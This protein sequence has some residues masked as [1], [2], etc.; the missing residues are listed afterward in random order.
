MLKKIVL[1]VGASFSALFAIYLLRRKTCSKNSKET[2]NDAKN[3]MKQNYVNNK[4]STADSVK[5]GIIQALEQDVLQGLE[6]NS[7]KEINDSGSSK[8]GANSDPSNELQSCSKNIVNEP[9]SLNGSVSAC[10]SET[11]QAKTSSLQNQLNNDH[12][13]SLT[14]TEAQDYQEDSKEKI[15]AIKEDKQ[16]AVAASSDTQKKPSEKASTPLQGDL[17]DT[18]DLP[19]ILIPETNL[20]SLEVIVSSSNSHLVMNGSDSSSSNHTMS[21]VSK[22]IASSQD[23]STSVVSS[24]VEIGP[25]IVSNSEDVHSNSVDTAVEA[26]DV[27]VSDTNITENIALKIVVSEASSEPVLTEPNDLKFVNE[28]VQQDSQDS[29]E[30]SAK[31]PQI[32]VLAADGQ[33]NKTDAVLGGSTRIENPDEYVQ[34]FDA[35]TCSTIDSLVSENTVDYG[36]TWSNGSNSVPSQNG[37]CVTLPDINQA[38]TELRPDEPQI[39]HFYDNHCFPVYHT[40]DDSDSYDQR[41]KW[42]QPEDGLVFVP[43]SDGQPLV[44]NYL[45]NVDF[46]KM[47]PIPS[48]N[49]DTLAFLANNMTCLQYPP[50]AWVRVI[51]VSECLQLRVRTDQRDMMC[52][53]MESLGICNPRSKPPKLDKL[54]VGSFVAAKLDVPGK[55]HVWCRAFITSV[56]QPAEQGAK[57]TPLKASRSKNSKNKE[58]MFMVESVDHF[59]AASTKPLRLSDLKKL[60]DHAWNAPF[61]DQPV[62]LLNTMPKDGVAYGSDARAFLLDLIRKGNNYLRVVIVFSTV[63]DSSLHYFA[64]LASCTHRV[65]GLEQLTYI[66]KELVSAGFATLIY[67]G[68]LA[69]RYFFHC[70]MFKHGQAFW[71]DDQRSPRPSM[72]SAGQQHVLQEYAFLL[73][74]DGPAVRGYRGF[75][76]PFLHDAWNSKK[77][78]LNISMHE[79]C[80][81]MKQP[82]AFIS[83]PE[84]FLLEIFSDPQSVFGMEL[85]CDALHFMYTADLKAKPG[86]P[87]IHYA[88]FFDKNLKTPL[89]MPKDDLNFLIPNSAHSLRHLYRK[90]YTVETLRKPLAV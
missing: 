13:G 24:I 19:D 41:R 3:S 15:T 40:G 90:I 50:E 68:S 30:N 49:P 48:H 56:I 57:E 46:L 65:R 64:S 22:F 2:T 70:C 82:G 20:T 39:C 47:R 23:A 43:A 83:D 89:P 71:Y 28:E 75:R 25:I 17:S 11:D 88:Y 69:S 55:G 6:C 63:I 33:V 34:G 53:Q 78:G 80:V 84:Q 8:N 44:P 1:V 38:A 81:V 26:C 58:P 52:E 42:P 12:L 67:S 86:D 36:S 7:K 59:P 72:A 29:S 27:A 74:E 9:L 14:P 32:F 76:L 66:E 45:R 4:P 61:F 16:L 62:S 87:D 21:D 51:S 77:L 85:Y 54:A 18:E 37:H 60:N 35:L 10:S 31:M 79:L 73:Y 5:N